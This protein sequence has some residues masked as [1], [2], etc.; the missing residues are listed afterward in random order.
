MER[1]LKYTSGQEP[2]ITINLAA[3]VILGIV[4]AATENWNLF[5]WDELSLSMAGFIALII[6]TGLARRG[7]FSPATH[8]AEVEEAL[9]TP[10]PQ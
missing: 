1:F 4:V 6:A 9:N 5:Q 2:V 7:V 3:A 8:A 10:P